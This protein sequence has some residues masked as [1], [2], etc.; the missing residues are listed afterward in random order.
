MM[1]HLIEHMS[2]C[3]TPAFVLDEG[4]IV[5]S[6][7]RVAAFAARCGCMF[8][9]SVKACSLS[10]VLRLLSPH[11]RGFSV[12]SPNEAELSRSVGGPGA[13]VQYV[14]PHIPFHQSREI[15]ELC[16]RVTFN[17]L[18]QLQRLGAC[19]DGRLDVGLRINPMLSFRDDERYDPCRVGSKL[20]VPAQLFAQLLQEDHVCLARVSGIH[21][22]SNCDSADLREL[23]ATIRHL[24]NVIGDGIA[25]FR[26]L[27]VGGGYLLNDVQG[28][29]RL[30]DEIVRLSDRYGLQVVIEPG[31]AIVRTAG[32]FVCS[33]EDIVE[34][35]EFPIAILDLTV[36]HW[37][38]VF[39]YQFEPDVEGHVDDGAYTYVLAG[40]SCLAGDLFGSYSFN[41][42]LKVGSR[43]IFENAGAYSIVKAHMF[44]GI[45]LPSIYAVTETGELVLIKQFAYEDFLARCGVDTNAAV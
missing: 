36:N 13:L 2:L 23:I 40:C 35:G 14:S 12:S 43:V 10:S 22:H 38:E 16:D 11:V 8:L 45:N 19:F 1:S 18:S 15:G 3:P 29:A 42:P 5:I 24:E 33:V 39:E 31:A 25:R 4:Q 17:S 30:A 41:E 44:N 26:W 28:L 34:G 37:P 32:Y 21:F 7:T 20:G 6:G 27:N 9:Y